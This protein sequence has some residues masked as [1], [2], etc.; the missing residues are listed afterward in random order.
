EAYF[1]YVIKW[2]EYISEEILFRAGAKRIQIFPKPQ[3]RQPP[4]AH[5]PPSQHIPH[6]I[7]EAQKARHV[8]RALAEESGAPI[9]TRKWAAQEKRK[10]EKRAKREADRRRDLA[11]KGDGS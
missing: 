3:L 1:L 5:N 7:G 11:K 8:E 4:P 6:W 10:Q 2:L 9:P